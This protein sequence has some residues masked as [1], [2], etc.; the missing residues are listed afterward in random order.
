MDFIH[1]KYGDNF[2]DESEV[3]NELDVNEVE[4]TNEPNQVEEVEDANEVEDD[5]EAEISGVSEEVSDNVEEEFTTI[6]MDEKENDDEEIIN[7]LKSKGIEVKSLDDLKKPKQ[8]VS[9]ELL[10]IQRFMDS[11]GKSADK[12]FEIF[13][14]YDNMDED[15]LIRAYH[16]EI[17]TKDKILELKLEELT[18]LEQDEDFPDESI[19]R[20]NKR[21][22]ILREAEVED[23]KQY[24]NKMKE[25]FK[26][27]EQPTEQELQKRE[28][29]RILKVKEMSNRVSG[30]LRPIEFTVG[31][32]KFKMTHGSDTK[33]MVKEFIEN[34]NKFFIEPFADENGFKS[35]QS[36]LDYYEN[37]L[38]FNK[39]SRE[40]MLD[41]IKKQVI[42]ATIENTSKG[43]RNVTLDDAKSSAG[44]SNGSNKGLEFW[45]NFRIR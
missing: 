14:D 43:K 25:D 23:A 2:T 13:R 19:E 44:R 6:S 8:V 7:V 39:E 15:E 36:E 9:E 12:Y 24:M 35:E 27:P 11:T 5:V 18:L 41:L 38:W 20:H 3:D 1:E 26:F 30:N 33:R 34:P 42:D 17:G 45:D 10:Q 22:K 28:E 16:N 37:A 40:K 4:D 29:E 32:K 31:Q 21:A